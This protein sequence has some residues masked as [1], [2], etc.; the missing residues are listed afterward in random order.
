ME[1]TW[2]PYQEAIFRAITTPNGG[3]LIVEAVAGSGKSTTLVEACGRTRGYSHVMLAFNKSVAEELKSRGVNGKTF[4]SACYSPVTRARGA[5]GVESN[6]LRM[7]CSEHMSRNDDFLYGSFACRLVGLARQGGVGCLVPDTI[8][9]WN[10]M[11]EHHDL[12][13]DNEGAT[14]ERAV[15][16]A[17][18]L[19]TWSNASHLVDFDDLLY[20]AV[21]DNIKLPQFDFVFVDEA[22]DTNMIQRTLLRKMM[23]PTSRLIAVGD[24]A[25][26]IYGFRGSDSGSLGLI[27]K[28]FFARTLPLTVSYRCGTDIVKY[29]RQ[30]VS[31]I[32]AA[33]GAPSGEV[34][35]M[36]K[37]WKTSMFGK[38]DLVVCRTTK[39][40]ITLAYRL[41]KDRIP[42]KILGRDI[43]AGLA[44]LIKKQKCNDID[45]LLVKIEAWAYREVEKAMA[46]KM[47][48]KAEA[49]QDKA[50]A[51]I[52]LADTL[53]EGG[54]TIPA[55][56]DVIY[57]LFDDK[58]GT[59]CLKLATIHKAKGME[60]DNVWW[61]NSSLC[62]ARWA[63]K[64]WQQEQERNICYVAATRA[65]T[66]L[67]LIEDGAGKRDFGKEKL[68]DK[69]P[70]MQQS[71]A[72]TDWMND[73][74]EDNLYPGAETSEDLNPLEGAK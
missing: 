37:E 14:Y 31:H 60:A 7:L 27:A 44:S 29:A 43:G 1:R 13:L 68:E 54:R 25:Q 69:E 71:D 4:H 63:R 42:A 48:S 16:L 64:P 66:Q 34:R 26:A 49:Q 47:D 8:D 2:S 73:S 40:L 72:M 39:P 28:E 22:Q 33:P 53:P 3:N 24:P 46:K 61:L 45:E 58:P 38:N 50:D 70:Q 51:I 65:K 5:P 55:L 35:K 52:C 15:E 74:E 59:D 30:W 67:N 6:K 57:Q 11:I 62:P 21:K 23:K 9:I 17:R 18:D 19:L 10:H 32:E 36:G 12:E 41:M 20:F 56:L